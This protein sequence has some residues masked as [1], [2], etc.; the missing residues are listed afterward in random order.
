MLQGTF[1][2][3]FIVWFFK[4]WYTETSVNTSRLPLK[5]AFGIMKD[6][7]KAAT[8]PATAE[9]PPIRVTGPAQLI[10]HLR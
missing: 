9:A 10:S 1:W 2:S 4:L 6:E 7:L 5:V 3:Y 8:E